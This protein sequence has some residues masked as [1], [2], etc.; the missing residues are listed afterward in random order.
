M[1]K[2]LQSTS[3]Q[4][5]FGSLFKRLNF[6]ALNPWRRIS[7]VIIFFLVGFFIGGSLGMI[8]GTLALMD[9]VGAFYT[10]LI[11]EVLI[12]NRINFQR[13]YEQKTILNLI[14]SFR[15]GLLYG[16]FMEGFKLF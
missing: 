12:R 10:V 6:W 8:N 7:L 9:P 15:I 2:K 1:T 5:N 11:I 16:L 4:N 14:D 3:L 13:K